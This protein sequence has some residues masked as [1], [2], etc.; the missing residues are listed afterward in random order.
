MFPTLAAVS[1]IV[2]GVAG[3]ITLALIL[4]FL[5]RVYERGGATDLTT[6]AEAVRSIRPSGRTDDTHPSAPHS[7]DRDKLD[8]D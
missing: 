5:W 2:T 8:C 1:L 4:R 7:G 6:A 3:V